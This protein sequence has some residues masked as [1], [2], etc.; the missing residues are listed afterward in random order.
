MERGLAKLA[1]NPDQ[2]FAKIFRLLYEENIKLDLFRRYD[3]EQIFELRILSVDGRFRGR[4]IAKHLMQQSQQ[5]AAARGFHVIKGEA[6]GLFSQKILQADDFV[7]IGEAK[8]AT[9]RN[10]DGSPMFPV[11]APHESL[12]IMMKVLTKSADDVN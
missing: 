3:T 12:K 7:V 8:Y 5:L 11:Q 9:K 6:T 2:H 10:A 1:N 4:G